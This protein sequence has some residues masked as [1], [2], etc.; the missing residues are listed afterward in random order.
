[1]DRRQ[2]SEW[3]E[4]AADDVTDA[5]D[6]GLDPEEIMDEATVAHRLNRVTRYATGG[7]AKSEPDQEKRQDPAS[8]ETPGPDPALVEEARQ[9]PEDTLDDAE[10]AQSV[11]EEPAPAE[12]A[13]QEPVLAEEEGESELVFSQEAHAEP[14]LAEEAQPEPA[15]DGDPLQ[16]VASEEEAPQEPAAFEEEPPEPT[17]PETA[18]EEPQEPEIADLLGTADPSPSASEAAAPAGRA[19]AAPAH[20]QP[21]PEALQTREEALR[22]DTPEQQATTAEPPAPMTDSD[23]DGG[24]V[25][26]VGRGI[27]LVAKL[28]ECSELLIEGH[29]EATARTRQLQVARGGRFIGSAEAE[30]AEIHGHYE[31]EL[32]VSKK[33]YIGP[34]GSVSGTTHYREIVIEA[35]GQIMGNTHHLADP[36]E[37]EAEG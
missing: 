28:C 5:R 20:G 36:G 25:L 24:E 16:S 14:V 7:A 23:P 10:T 11:P 18:P 9:E 13:Q 1:M 26:S 8:E 3:S 27:R 30:Y 29:L 22:A 6:S 35:G 19:E 15:A 12:E 37:A 34:T 31:G 17:P 4:A 2:Q 21:E 33:L 32:T